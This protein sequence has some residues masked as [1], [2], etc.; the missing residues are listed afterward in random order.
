M[1]MLIM[2]ISP[3][4]QPFVVLTKDRKD[5]GLKTKFAQMGIE[6]VCPIENYIISDHFSDRHKHLN[7][8]NFLKDILQAVNFHLHESVN[9][10]TQRFEWMSFLMQM[11]NNI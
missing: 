3:G 1:L 4:I 6:N 7:F 8:L 10:E 5:S 2:Y 9:F 11:A